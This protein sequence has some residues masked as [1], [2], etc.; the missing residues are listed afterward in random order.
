MN[1]REILGSCFFLKFLIRKNIFQM[2]AYIV[3]RGVKEFCHLPLGKP[4]GVVVE[5]HLNDALFYLIDNYFTVFILHI[6]PP[7]FR[8]IL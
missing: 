7:T 1:C 2:E 3:S 8:L 5:P 6:K 4:D